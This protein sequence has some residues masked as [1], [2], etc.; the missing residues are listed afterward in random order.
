L[1]SVLIS[2]LTYMSIIHFSFFIVELQIQTETRV[3][4]PNFFAGTKT[5][6]K[7]KNHFLSHRNQTNNVIGP[8][9]K[10]PETEPIRK[11]KRKK[12]FN[13]EPERKL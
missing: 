13:I 12:D 6:T 10:G 4:K 2:Y 11:S 8:G 1:H 7:P 5:G 3:E 9:K